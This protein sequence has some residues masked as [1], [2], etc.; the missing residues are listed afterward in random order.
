VIL[1]S[2]DFNFFDC[3][4][5]GPSVGK[6]F[7]DEFSDNSDLLKMVRR[8]FLASGYPLGYH[9]AIWHPRARI[10]DIIKTY[11]HLNI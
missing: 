3:D 11:P 4:F 5:H 8:V 2:G 7:E 1:G 6:G 10:Q 9:D